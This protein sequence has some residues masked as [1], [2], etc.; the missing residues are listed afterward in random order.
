VRFGPSL[1]IRRY[2]FIRGRPLGVRF[3]CLA[4]TSPESSTLFIASV[5]YIGMEVHTEHADFLIM[6][7]TK[8][9]QRLGGSIKVEVKEKHISFGWNFSCFAAHLIKLDLF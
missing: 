2:I 7:N 4:Q 1:K 6:S 5:Q 9:S 8:R 3:E